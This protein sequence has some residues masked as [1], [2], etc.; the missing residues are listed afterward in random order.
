MLPLVP[1]VHVDDQVLEVVLRTVP[2]EPARPPPLI[3]RDPSD[4]LGG[5]LL[6]VGVL[7][8]GLLS[9]LPSPLLDLTIVERG[10]LLPEQVEARCRAV[11]QVG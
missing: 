10:P 3:D 1:V 6:R 11:A 8:H 7:S 5:S 2:G 9:R 4:Q